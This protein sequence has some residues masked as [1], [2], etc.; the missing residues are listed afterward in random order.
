MSFA[1]MT[2]MDKVDAPELNREI[3]KLVLK[4]LSRAR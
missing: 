3:A 4:G 2:N 1:L